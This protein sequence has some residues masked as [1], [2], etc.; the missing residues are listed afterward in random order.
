MLVTYGSENRWVLLQ[1]KARAS[2]ESKSSW[3]KHYDKNS[4]RRISTKWKIAVMALNPRRQLQQLI[5]P[6][7]L[8]SYLAEFI[9]TFLFIFVAVGSSMSA[10]KA[11][12]PDLSRSRPP[13]L[14]SPPSTLPQTHPVATTVPQCSTLLLLAFFF[15]SPQPTNQFQRW[16]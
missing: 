1:V 6:S 7:A 2:I 5:S 10:R 16:E 8:R 9:S 4:S 3:W 13:S 11:A 15:T 12:L 14:S